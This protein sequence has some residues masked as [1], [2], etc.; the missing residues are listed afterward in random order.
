MGSART[1]RFPVMAAKTARRLLLEAQGLLADP[2]R[3]TTLATVEKT[4]HTMGFVQLDTI[5]VV[6]R[7]HHLTLFSRLDGYKPDQ[8]RQLHE[9]KRRLFEHWTH[10]ASLL[11]VEYLSR[12][13]H[14]RQRIIEQPRV[15]R[16]VNRNL[17]DNPTRT[18]N[19]VL[20]RIDRD[21]P[22][23]SQDFAGS[24]G[25]S[26]AWW[27]WKP[28]KTALEYLWWR[29]DLTVVARAS[30][31]KVYDLTERAYPEYNSVDPPT[32]KDF[33]AWACREGI[34]RL[35]TG[36]PHEIAAFFGAVTLDEAKRWCAEAR[37]RG[38]IVNVMVGA[39][40]KSSPRQSFAV[41]DWRRRAR[42]ADAAVAEL[43][44]QMR[45][46][47]PFDPVIRDRRRARR[48][49]NFD[50]RFE[51]FVPAAKRRFGYYVLP[52]MEG[53]RLVGRCDAKFHRARKELEIKGLWW[54]PAVKATRVR[55]AAFSRAVQ[56]LAAFVAA[57]SVL[58]PPR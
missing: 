4:I 24:K 36:T 30:F 32:E 41:S 50:Y 37:D 51:A 16:W 8:L 39:E 27:G 20:R 44:G 17:G 58:M 12:W 11:P 21:G 3:R 18:L 48:L 34:E 55:R 26:G 28:A 15:Q 45:L 22:L 35:G 9:K 31:R 52:I 1:N 19:A 14:R 7:A 5:N 23:Q 46:L 43:D 2:S 57:R 42:R 54:E 33:V 40:D 56:Q 47:S 6:E 10:D 13:H 29:G 25:S 38:D 49:F 53:E